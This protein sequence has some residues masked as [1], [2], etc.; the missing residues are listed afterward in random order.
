[1]AEDPLKHS[2]VRSFLAIPLGD[3][4]HEELDRILELLR[5]EVHGVRW[6]RSGQIHLTLHF[7]GS[8]PAN[9]IGRIDGSMQKI[10]SSFDPLVL[11]MD[12]LGGF[13]DLK[14]PNVLWLGIQEKTGALRLLQSAVQEEVRRLGFDI[15]AK[16]FYP[17]ATV[18]RVQERSKNPGVFFEKIP[19]EFPTAEKALDH[20]TLYQSHCLP[21]GA[22]YDVLKIYPFS[23]KA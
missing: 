23:K 2:L 4:F 21:E 20:F 10:A 9:E 3:V 6:A 22:R 16:P 7:F 15:E 12:R 19:S 13:P 17:H 18:G 14:K 11:S 8:I 1:M 5:G